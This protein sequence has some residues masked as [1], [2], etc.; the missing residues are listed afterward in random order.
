MRDRDLVGL[1]IRNNENVQYKVVGMS[2]RRRDQLKPDVA[3]GVLGK[4]VQ[5]NARLACTTDSKC[6]WNTLECL[7]VTVER[8]SR[9]KGGP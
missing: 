1:R 5:S 7:Q 2:F 6:T 4:V 3:W 9:R 8:L